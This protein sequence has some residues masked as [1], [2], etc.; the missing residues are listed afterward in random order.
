MMQLKQFHC[1]WNERVEITFL[2]LAFCLEDKI[3]SRILKHLVIN[4]GNSAIR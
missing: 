2:P 3:V 4:I 1:L